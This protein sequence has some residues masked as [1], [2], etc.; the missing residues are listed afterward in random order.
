MVKPGGSGKGTWPGRERL[1]SN[2]EK[3]HWGAESRKEDKFPPPGKTN[4]REGRWPMCIA[5]RVE[6]RAGFAL[7]S[8]EV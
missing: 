7:V 2:E 6:H 1:V 8:C 5:G 4:F 3:A